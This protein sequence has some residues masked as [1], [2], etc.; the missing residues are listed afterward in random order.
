MVIAAF[1]HIARAFRWRLQLRQV[2]VQAVTIQCHFADIGTQAADA[3]AQHLFINAVLLSFCGSQDDDL[4]PLFPH[5]ASPS[6]S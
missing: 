1:S 3:H 4:V 6:L 2:E 5:R